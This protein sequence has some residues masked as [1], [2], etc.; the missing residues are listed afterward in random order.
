MLSFQCHCIKCIHVFVS[1][2]CVPCRMFLLPRIFTNK[3]LAE[4]DNET[5]DDYFDEH[6]DAYAE[7]HAVPSQFNLLTDNKRD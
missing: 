5:L 6:D 2:L 1:V 4:V 7:S 3:E